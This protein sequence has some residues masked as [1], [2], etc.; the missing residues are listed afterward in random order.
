MI[1]IIMELLYGNSKKN[2]F[3]KI[4]F[5][6][7]LLLLTIILL[8]VYVALC[9]IIGIVIFF[10]LF[11]EEEKGEMLGVCLF[12]ILAETIIIAMYCLL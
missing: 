12:S 4:A 5:I 11:R 1:G 9:F 6:V 8:H 2:I 3:V 7:F 10:I